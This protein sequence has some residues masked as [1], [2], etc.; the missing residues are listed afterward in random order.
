MSF[1][2]RT[3]HQRGVTLVELILFIVIVSVA[4]IGII[5]VMSLTT[6]QSAD[7]VRRK[8]AL[9]LAEGLLEEVESAKFS[10][11]DPAD[12][13]A[14]TGTSTA[15]CASIPEN[16]GQGGSEPVN[17]RPFDNINDYV[18]AAGQATAAFDVGGTLRDANGNALNLAG[19]SARLTIRPAILGGVGSADAAANTEVLRITVRVEYDGQSVELDGYR[20]RYA[21]N[22]L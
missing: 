14:A 17:A 20:F 1:N 16:W 5:G 9:I 12:D 22:S 4:L 8:Q 3:S 6:K 10:Y 7:P 11:C 2:P 13:N 19:Y 21:P 15:G 18:A